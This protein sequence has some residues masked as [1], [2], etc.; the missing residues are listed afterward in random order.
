MYIIEDGKAYL[1]DGEVGYQ[2]NFDTTGK[3]LIEKEKTIEVVGKIT[4]SYDEIYA[5]LNIAYM[6]EEA[7]KKNALKGIV[8]NEV[9]GL[10]KQIEVLKNENEQLKAE[11]K[12]YTADKKEENSKEEKNTSKKEK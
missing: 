5:K 8:S 7:K 2:I 9:E 6:I 4:Y 12:K 11:L 10:N 3:M 1:V